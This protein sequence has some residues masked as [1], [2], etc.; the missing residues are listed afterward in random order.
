MIPTPPSGGAPQRWGPSKLPKTPCQPQ[1]SSKTRQPK[2]TIQTTKT[3]DHPAKQPDHPSIS[4]QK[5]QQPP[6][7]PKSPLAAADEQA[8]R[9]TPHSRQCQND[10]TLKLSRQSHET[11]TWQGS[12]TLCYFWENCSRAQLGGWAAGLRRR[13]LS[14]SETKA[15]GSHAFES[16]TQRR[17]FGR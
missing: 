11:R 16:A 17:A 4:A 6:A 5:T 13:A 1:P 12:I 7:E 3:T 10:R 8:S 2:P 15:R 9:P 14:L